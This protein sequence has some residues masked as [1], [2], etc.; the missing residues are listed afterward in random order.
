MA[1]FEVLLQ[2]ET[3]YTIEAENEEKALEK[4]F[5]YWDSYEP[6]Y[7]INEVEEEE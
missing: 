7:E 4:A 1:K 2:A 5:E 3:L 6:F